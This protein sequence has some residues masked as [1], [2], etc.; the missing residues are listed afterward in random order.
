MTLSWA[1]ITPLT[2]DSITLTLFIAGVATAFTV[3]MAAGAATGSGSTTLT[4][5]GGEAIGVRLVQ[6]STEAQA[7][8]N[9]IVS[10]LIN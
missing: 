2:T 8:W 9:G 6:S 3:T 7:A 1:A 10:V 5:A 4:F